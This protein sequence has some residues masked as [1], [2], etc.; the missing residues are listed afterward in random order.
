VLCCHQTDANCSGS[1]TKCQV[2]QVTQQQQQQR[3]PQQR[4]LRGYPD[5]TTTCCAYLDSPMCSVSTSKQAQ[6]AGHKCCH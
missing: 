6:K 3:E 1:M 5:T 4:H 2:T